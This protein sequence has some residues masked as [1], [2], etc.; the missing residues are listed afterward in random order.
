MTALAAAAV[1]L[2]TDA[3]FAQRGAPPSTLA[4]GPQLAPAPFASLRWRAIGPAVFGGRF[5]DIEVARVPGQ[6]DQIYITASTGGVFKSTNGGASFTPIFDGV[7]AMLSMGDL[8]IAPSNPDIIWVGTGEWAN[9]PHRWGDG[10]YKSTDAGRTW[11]KMGLAESRHI[12]RIVIHPTNPDIVFVAAQGNIWGPHPERGVFKT[13]DGGRTWRKVLYVDE[14]TG[15]NDVAL[16]PSNPQ[17][18]FASTYTRQRRSFGGIPTGAG[19]GLH[20]S[21]DGGETWT[22]VTHEHAVH[23]GVRRDRGVDAGRPDRLD[24]L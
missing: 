23:R 5:T 19:S 17:I 11:Q 24:Q 9:P 7:N 2:P 6:L 3:S 8:A 4:N 16:D 14:N 12:G 10:V 21:T 1:A 18:V 22:P 20:K 13:T 15:A